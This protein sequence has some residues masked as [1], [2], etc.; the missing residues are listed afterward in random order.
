MFLGLV[1]LVVTFF[2]ERFSVI[3]FWVDHWHLE[4]TRKHVLGFRSLMRVAETVPYLKIKHNSE[5]QSVSVCIE[6]VLTKL[7]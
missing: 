7:R 3:F 6:S 2:L 5:N 1:T 4:L